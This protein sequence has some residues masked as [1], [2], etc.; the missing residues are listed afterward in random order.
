VNATAPLRARDVDDVA[1]IEQSLEIAAAR[2]E[3]LTPLVYERFFVR[4]PDA[5]PYFEMHDL[6]PRSH[7]RMLAEIL[8][9]LLDN[10][11]HERYVGPTLKTMVSDHE[12]YG[13]LDRSFYAAF[14]EALEE[15]MAGLVAREWTPSMAAAFGRQ[16][17][18]LLETLG[19]R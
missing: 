5:K 9:L 11:R 10:A 16:R 4:R 14:L 3:D 7:G 2:C 19:S 1:L 18:A 12:S 15:V 8:V 13:V 6:D 17:A